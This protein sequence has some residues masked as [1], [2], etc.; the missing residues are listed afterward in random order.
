MSNVN[1]VSVGKPKIGGA[2]SVAAKG[3][4][5]PNDAITAL[6]NTFSSLGYISED[7]L[8]NNNT[9]TSEQIKA[10]GGD[11]VLTPSTEKPDY[12]TFK[13]IEVLSVDVLKFI[14]GDTHVTGTLATG[15][16]VTATSEEAQEH[17]AAIDMIM[18]GALKR[19]VIPHA[20]I[21]EVAEIVYSDSDAV[22][23][24]VTVSALPDS[25]GVTHYEYIITDPATT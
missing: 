18:N 12:F 10:W 5:L 3:T 11:V 1:N 19:I 6:A 13:L 14:Y 8:S 9:A 24:E 17:V 7:G 20:K 2:V 16:S 4:D 15:I 23:Y 21:T 22:G 25:N